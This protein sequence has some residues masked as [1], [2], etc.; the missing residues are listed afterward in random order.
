MLGA[1]RGDNLPESQTELSLVFLLEEIIRS[2]CSCLSLF[3]KWR[4]SHW[5]NVYTCWD[6]WPQLFQLF[7]WSCWEWGSFITGLWDNTCIQNATSSAKWWCHNSGCTLSVTDWSFLELETML[8]SISLRKVVTTDDS[9]TV[10]GAVCKGRIAG[11]N[12]PFC[13]RT[14]TYISWHC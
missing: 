8:G 7:L 6:C 5:D 2:F 12:G 13:Y 9:L 4:K 1:H 3:Q 10:W 14:H 11:E